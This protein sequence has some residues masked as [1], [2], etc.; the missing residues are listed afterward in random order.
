MEGAENSKPTFKDYF[1]SWKW[2]LL[3]IL[4]I[5][6]MKGQ[7]RWEENSFERLLFYFTGMS[8]YHLVTTMMIIYHRDVLMSGTVSIIYIVFATY[9]SYL[10]YD[11]YTKAGLRENELLVVKYCGYVFVLL[12]IGTVVM[13][14]L[15]AQREKSE[16]T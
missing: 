7:E 4:F 16:Q 2:V 11:N 10:V 12:M 13:S 3:P 1:S 15:Q 5:T 6:V 14:Y 9:Q 8:I